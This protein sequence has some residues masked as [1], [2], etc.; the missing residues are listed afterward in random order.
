MHRRPEVTAQEVPALLGRGIGLVTAD[1]A[2]RYDVRTE[3]AHTVHEAG[4][5]RIMQQDNVDLADHYLQARQVMLQDACVMLMLGGT[6]VGRCGGDAMQRVVNPSCV[7]YGAVDRADHA[8]VPVP[9]AG[10]FLC[11]SVGLLIIYAAIRLTDVAEFRRLSR[12]RRRASRTPDHAK[13]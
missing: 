11:R 6:E 9:S 5:L 3:F 1:V 4:C 12:F 2:T 10:P 7:L 13:L 8:R